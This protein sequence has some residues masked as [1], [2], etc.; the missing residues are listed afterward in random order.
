MSRVVYLKYGDQVEQAETSGSGALNIKRIS[1]LFEVEL[2]PDSIKLNGISR[3][4]D[5]SYNT[6]AA[7]LG[8][9]QD[10]PIIVSG[11]QKDGKRL[12]CCT[13]SV[14]LCLDQWHLQ[15]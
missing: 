10:A 2:D 15:K 11:R 13:S 14:F 4:V 3:D 5:A 1:K 9:T 6:T 8:G 12:L 7:V